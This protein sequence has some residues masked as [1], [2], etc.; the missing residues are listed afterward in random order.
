MRREETGIVIE[1]SE[2]KAKVKASRHGDCENCGVCPGDNAMVVEVQNLI[3][4]KVGQRV[5]FEIQEANMLW[6][7]FVVYLLPLLALFVGA[8]GGGILGT[9]LGQ[10]VLAFQI[11][12][13]SVF[14]TVAVIYLK[15]Y[16]QAVKKNDKL[17]PV[18]TKILY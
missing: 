17:L 4:A 10:P 14:F 9:N 18:I 13:G 8:L 12:G 11:V 7:A 6:A 3:G 15:R 5:A 2:N 16:D 1:T